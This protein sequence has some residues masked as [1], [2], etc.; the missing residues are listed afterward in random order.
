MQ[1]VDWDTKERG[2]DIIQPCRIIEKIVLPAGHF[3]PGTTDGQF[4]TASTYSPEIVDPRFADRTGV[5]YV[6]P[7]SFGKMCEILFAEYRSGG[8]RFQSLNYF[9]LVLAYKPGKREGHYG[10]WSIIEND[11]FGWIFFL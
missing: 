10:S 3:H 9:I 2:P 5:P 6:I 4:Y 1:A 11:I 7:D 8:T